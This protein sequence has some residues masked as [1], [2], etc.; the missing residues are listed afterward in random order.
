MMKIMVA[1]VPGVGKTSF[2]YGMLSKMMNNQRDYKIGLSG[3]NQ[4]IQHISSLMKLSLPSSDRFPKKSEPRETYTFRLYNREEMLTE[5]E[6]VDFNSAYTF[7]TETYE[8]DCLFLCLDGSLIRGRMNEIDGVVNR[9]YSTN[10][11]YDL[12]RILLNT[13]NE[14]GMYPSV[15]VV[16]TK[17]DKVSQE[18]RNRQALFSIVE[19]CFP[20]L[21]SGDGYSGR[22]LTIC[23]VSLGKEIQFGGKLETKNVELPLL[24]A[25]FSKQTWLLKMMDDRSSVPKELLDTINKLLDDI[26]KE[27]NLLPLYLSGKIENWK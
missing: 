17:Y 1:G 8:A 25:V 7:E 14:Y 23:P 6:W 24:F 2:F 20:G 10:S 18:L 16:I 11:V 22:M 4:T 26:K 19:K 15:C 5:V 13:F 9:L 21:F 12:N 3:G 27:I